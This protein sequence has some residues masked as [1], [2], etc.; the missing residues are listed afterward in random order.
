MKNKL[1]PILSYLWI[2]ILSFL[3]F[4]PYKLTHLVWLIPLGL[5]AIEKKYRGKPKKLILHG[6]GAAI[7]L[8]LFSYIWINHLLVVF[9]GFPFLLAFPLFLFYSLVTGWKFPVF[10][11]LLTFLRKKFP[12][13]ILPTVV[14]SILCAELFTFQLFPWFFGNL[15]AGNKF[16]AQNVEYTG[17]YGLSALVFLISYPL[18]R[19][20]GMIGSKKLF[21]KRL[22]PYLLKLWLPPLLVLILFF[23][24][25]IYLYNKWSNHTPSSKKE[26]LMIQPD[27]PLEFRDGRSVKE[28][29]EN[30]MQRIEDYTIKSAEEKK[31]DIIVL[32]ESGIPFFSTHNTPATTLFNRIYY[33][34]FEALVYLL[35]KRNRS[36]VFLNEIDAIFI[37]DKQDRKNQRFYNNSVLF[38]P[39]GERKES[40]RKNY[41]LAFGEYFPGGEYFPYIYELIPQVARFLPGTETNLITYYKN[42]LDPPAFRKSHLRLMDS[43]LM[44]VDMIKDYYKEYTTKVEKDGEFLPLICYEVIIPEFVRKFGRSG[45][46]DFI[47]N[48]TN[49]KWYGNDKWYSPETFQHLELARLRSIEFRRWMV[50]STNSGTS[51]FV[52]HLGN[53]VN[54]IYT[55]V[56]TSTY[57]STKVSIIQSEPTFYVK[58]GNLFIWLYLFLYLVFLGFQYFHLGESK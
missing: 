34:R 50:R 23:V 36:N 9:G 29:I 55:D 40:Y 46:P 4:I 28:T 44:S 52:D 7:S 33:H 39:N 8:N 3:A 32:P 10:L 14:F 6:L 42:V 22:K 17:V 16:L 45:N 2:G 18:Y 11:L 5:F 26:I 58:F 31:P 49:D 30:L 25:G 54:N 51:A 37:D 56:E 35:A 53:I 1:F 24:H 43:N 15:L 41:L 13:H 21:Y 57:Y 47:I 27:A 38:D 19:T 48:I 20:L 12:R